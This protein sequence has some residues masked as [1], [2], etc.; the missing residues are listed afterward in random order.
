MEKENASPAQLTAAQAILG[1]AS[2]A[3][4][5][6]ATKQAAVKARLRAKARA[7]MGE[8]AAAALDADRAA[9]RALREAES[10]QAAQVASERL[11]EDTYGASA[12]RRMSRQERLFAQEE[13]EE[14]E[15]ER[16]EAEAATDALLAEER[17]VET[18]RLT[19][20]A[21]ARAA[22]RCATD[23][24]A[25]LAKLVDFRDRAELVG[26][27]AAL[28]L[29]EEER[30]AA[31]AAA[32]AEAADAKLAAEVQRKFERL[33]AKYDDGVAA[34]GQLARDVAQR[35]SEGESKSK[36][37]GGGGGG[38]GARAAQPKKKGF[39]SMMFGK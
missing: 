21:G 20:V 1:D 39:R 23:E 34:D 26:G 12:A 19:D 14:A 10:Q 11:K 6:P 37:G 31:R 16:E 8:E 9:A 24:D 13:A 7:A 3:C 25:A 17:R 30:R 29:Q 15:I 28:K 38:G 18:L 33:D 27:D 2:L 22:A 4:A 32:D 35:E 36:S 5:S